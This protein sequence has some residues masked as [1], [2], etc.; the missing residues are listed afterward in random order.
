MIWGEEGSNQIN[1]FWYGSF[2]S[3]HLGIH[4]PGGGG[5]GDNGL[6]RD[7]PPQRGTFFMLQVYERV[8]ISRV[9]VYEWVGKSVVQV[10]KRA[11]ILRVKKGMQCS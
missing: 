9:T 3:L 8:G 2:Q 6:Y 10:F 5:G 11:S 4:C 1:I 7:A